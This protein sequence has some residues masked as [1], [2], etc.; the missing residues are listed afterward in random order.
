MKWN[1]FLIVAL[2]VVISTVIFSSCKKKKQEEKEEENQVEEY[3]RK[4]MLSNLANNYIVP[5]Y[6]NYANQATT[7][8][9]K[10]SAFNTTTDEANLLALRTQWETTLLAWQEV[11]F[12]EFGPAANVALISQTN[13]YPV[14]T[15]LIK[16]NISSG[17][18]NLQSTSN[19]VAKG[20]QA[21]DYLINGTGTTDAAIVN[22][23]LS[24]T[25]A[26][27]YLTDVVAEIKQ[28]ANQV[29]GE[30]NNTYKNTFVE[31][32][33]SNSEGSSVS[34]SVNALSLIYEA[35]IR[36]GKIGLP[37]GVF[38]G[39]TQEPMPSHVEAYFYKKSMLFAAKSME[40]IY[41]F[42]NGINYT[43]EEN[44]QG[45]DDYLNFVNATYNG[46][47]LSVAINNQINTIISATNSTNDPFSVEVVNNNS[48]TKQLYDKYQALVPLI[49]V[50][51]TSALGVLVTYQDNDGD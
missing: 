43:T 41:N 30:W 12:L 48:A 35:H 51:M 32:S 15:T 45:Y 25:N 26:K 10:V 16:N 39:F 31:N 7:L 14:D 37:V 27:T 40:G 22:Y 28:L 49:K 24:S 19:F 2:S 33:A 5:A 29:S 3:D 8:E 18:Y 11:S 9:A 42:I 4:T 23:F 1:K 34:E 21:L 44:G 17:T 47:K 38:N 46:E 50:D 36:K 13:I 20:F 6:A